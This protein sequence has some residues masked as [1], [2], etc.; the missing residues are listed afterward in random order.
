MKK[1][2]INWTVKRFN[3]EVSNEVV[4]F[5]YPIQRAGGQWDN[6]QK[7]LLIHSVACDYPVP[8]LYALAQEE[9]IGEGDK[10]RKTL[11]YYLLDGKQRTTNIR[12]FIDGKYR[13][14]ADTPKFKIEGKEYDLA[15]FNF[16]ELPV[17]VKD[18]IQDF[19]LDIYKIE[20]ATDD[21]IED[22]FFRLNNGTP[23]TQVQK[24]KAKMG[25]ETAVLLQEL[26]SHSL[27]KDNAVFTP[28]QIR[29]ADNEVALLQAMMLLDKD[30]KVSKFGNNDVFEYASS[31]RGSKADVFNAT[32][33]TLDYLAE[34]LGDQVEK[35]LL[36]KLHFPFVVWASHEALVNEVPTTIFSTWLES[37]KEKINSKENAVSIGGLPN[38]N[39]WLYKIGCGAGATKAEKVSDRWTATKQEIQDL[40]NNLEKGEKEDAKA[41]KQ[42]ELD[43]AEKLKQAEEKKAL[44]KTQKEAKELEKAQKEAEIKA[45]KKAELE[46]KLEAEKV[47]ELNVNQTELKI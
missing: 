38:K 26:S 39:A 40:L 19:T 6:L 15:K 35:V 27:M 1:S 20:E 12:D 21:E 9:V 7:S 8:P 31:L 17:E 37:F 16:E 33:K 4:S 43:K 14:D 3:K 28:L 22:M 34:T 45:P 11:V 23:L 36:R 32:K 47:T 46:A 24:A 5:D 42:L 2:R 29:K 44:A 30:Y 10:A 13:L 18:A 41:K 25:S